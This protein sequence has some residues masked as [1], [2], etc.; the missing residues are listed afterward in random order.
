[1]NAVDA[2]DLKPVDDILVRHPRVTGN[3]ISVLHEVQSHYSYL[4]EHALRH[5]AKKSGVPITRLYSIATFYHFFSLEPKGRHQIH[6][7]LG[8][9]CHVKGGQR[10]L[11]EFERKLGVRAGETT[12]DLRYTV[13]EVRCVGACSF[14]PAVVVGETMYADVTPKKVSDILRKH[15]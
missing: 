1:V 4:P 7:C 8:T 12:P 9:A 3:L 11:E 2:T 15:R 10:V 5:L 6:V 13:D 14:A